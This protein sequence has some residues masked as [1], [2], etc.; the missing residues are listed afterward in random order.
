MNMS[1]TL[2]WL[3]SLPSQDWLL[4]LVFEALNE[5]QNL[6]SPKQKVTLVLVKWINS[7][8]SNIV[9]R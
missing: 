3:P 6:G 7:Q 4:Q 5:M 9:K 8:L 2:L 1:A